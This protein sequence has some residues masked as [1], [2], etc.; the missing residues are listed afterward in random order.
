MENYEVALLSDSQG[1]VL[2]AKKVTL[3]FQ[4]GMTD[5]SAGNLVDVN[6]SVDAQLESIL[7]DGS[8]TTGSM[9]QVSIRGAELEAKLLTMADG[10]EKTYLTA[11]L[12]IWKTFNFSLQAAM[13]KALKAQRLLDNPATA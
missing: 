2:K 6:L 7:R 9:T 4:P 8:V 11:K 13:S 1:V 5:V 10:E 12:G 3:S